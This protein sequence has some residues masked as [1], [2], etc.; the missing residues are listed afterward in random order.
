MRAFEIHLNGKKLC[1]AGIGDHGVLSVIVDWVRR[2]SGPEQ[3]HLSVGGMIGGA[4][5][6]LSWRDLRLRAG[7]E[8]LVKVIDTQSADRPR[9]RRLPDAT[10]DLRAQKRYVREMARKFGWKIQTRP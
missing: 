4:L 3:L 10:A 2:K 1:T 9:R 8:V 7:D 6:H 5:E